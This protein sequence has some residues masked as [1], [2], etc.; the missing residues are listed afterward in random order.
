MALLPGGMH[1]HC[2]W[3]LTAPTWRAE[4]ALVPAQG[5]ALVP[6]WAQ[7]QAQAQAWVWARVQ[8]PAWA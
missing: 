6:A 4:L 8:A 7:A 3:R 1:R 5:P 2:W